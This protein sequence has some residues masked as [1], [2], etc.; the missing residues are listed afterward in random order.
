MNS[1]SIIIQGFIVLIAV[2]FAIRLFS[3]QVLSDEYKLAAQNNIVQRIVE[4]PYRG[5]VYDRNHKLVVYNTPVFDLMIVPKEVNLEDSVAFRQLLDM[6]QATY[7]AKYTKARRFS[8]ILASKFMEQMPNEVF[9]GIQDELVEFDGFYV[10][11]RT[12]REYPE[13]TLA[14]ALG[15][16][17]EISRYQLNS[18]TTNYYR[19]GDYTGI[20]GIE[21][22]YERVLRGKRG[23]NFKIVNVQGVVKGAFNDGI[24]DTT[25]IPGKTIQLT[26]DSELQK[27]AEK[28]MAGKVGSIVAIDP[29][30][31]E[32]LAYVSAPSYDP[33]WL[34]GKRLND[35]YPDLETD[36]LKPLFNRPIQAVYPPG[37][38]FKTIQALVA[39]QA[40]VL[41]PYEKIMCDGGPMGDHAPK[42]IYDV[43][44][45]I[46]LS[47]NTF[48]YK[49]FRRIILR[50]KNPNMYI[51]S[52]I[53]LEQWYN[54]VYKFGLGHPLGVDLPGE[55]S[56]NLPTVQYYDRV[57]GT[58]RWKFSNIYSVSIGQGEVGVTP[59]QMAN[60]AAIIANRG[61]YYTP[62]VV[63]GIDGKDRPDV[64]RHDVGVDARY[65]E[66]VVDGMA[67][68]VLIGTGR[69]A[70]IPGLVVCGKTSTVENPHGEDHSGFMAFAPK[71]NP[72]IAI[73]AYVENAGQGARA[74]ASAASLLIEKYINGE[75]KRTYLEEYML[76]GEFGDP[77]PKPK[78]APVDSAKINTK[79]VTAR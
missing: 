55:K 69:R 4:Y 3:I 62:H 21:R 73:S 6:D 78:K 38:M 12:V 2:I 52:R 23:V 36:S 17:R 33:N 28:L 26:V 15:Y 32:I 20:V 70:F 51:D 44:R 56:G 77:K 54:A 27:Y 40:G 65:Y 53:G 66:P 50:D 35:H 29:S 45:A 14:N 37:S 75:V 16:V 64:H 34:S 43:N 72:K 25:S 58:N 39:M 41:G 60:L 10:L 19:S 22:S 24:Y 30:T 67:N 1:R 61:Y 48:M 8:P 31:G 71:D 7:D 18:D 47:S 74:A 42:G 68:V 59:I 63:R 5:L 49:V 9:A 11:P 76:R 57:Y 13:N 46:T 79:A